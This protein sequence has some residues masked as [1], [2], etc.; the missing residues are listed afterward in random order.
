M[1]K[2][3]LKTPQYGYLLMFD[4]AIYCESMLHSD[5]A[6]SLRLDRTD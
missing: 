5:L 6:L 3:T 4:D 1:D 2:E